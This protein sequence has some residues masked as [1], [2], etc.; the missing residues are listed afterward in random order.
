VAEEVV[1]RDVDDGRKAE[2]EEEEDL[3]ETGEEEEE[4]A[5]D[6]SDPFEG[7]EGERLD[8]RPDGKVEEG[9]EG[10]KGRANRRRGRNLEAPD[11]GGDP[12]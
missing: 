9:N 7:D 10:G 6:S 11:L 5:A 12:V 8:E 2:K 1:E 3:V 4:A